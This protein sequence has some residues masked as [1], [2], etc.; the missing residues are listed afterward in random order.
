MDL[1]S[2]NIYGNLDAKIKIGG[3]EAP[4]LI[5]VLVIAAF[6]N[7]LFGETALF[8]PLVVVLPT[9]LLLILLIGKRNKPDKFLVHLIKYLITPGAYSAGEMSK[10]EQKMKEC[11]Y[12]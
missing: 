10:N 8:F 9:T 1:D 3:L 12:E 2:S 6:M 4:D 5:I 7:L 11:I